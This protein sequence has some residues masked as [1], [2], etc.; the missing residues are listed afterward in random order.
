MGW[1]SSMELWEYSSLR[2]RMTFYHVLSARHC[3]LDP[4]SSRERQRVYQTAVF[5]QAT[6][7]YYHDRQRHYRYFL[8]S[9][10]FVA[11]LRIKGACAGL[12]PMQ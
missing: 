12:D 10:P 8:V 1:I 4:Q 11:G 3:G 6:A 5:R 2:Y 7:F 9:L